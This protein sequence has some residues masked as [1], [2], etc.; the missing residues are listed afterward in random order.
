MNITLDVGSLPDDNIHTYRVTNVETNQ[1]L[2]FKQKYDKVK[3][4]DKLASK[5]L[6]SKR[7]K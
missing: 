7:W 1:V 6:R 2:T 5:I 4:A 3:G